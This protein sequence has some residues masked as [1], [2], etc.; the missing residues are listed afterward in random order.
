[1]DLLL[2]VLPEI[3]HEGVTVERKRRS[4]PEINPN[5]SRRMVGS[6]SRERNLSGSY[7]SALKIWFTSVRLSIVP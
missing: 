2:Y 7:I 1:M 3:D 4:S 5:T 6:E